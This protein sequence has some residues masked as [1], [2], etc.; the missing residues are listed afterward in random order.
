MGLVPSFIRAYFKKR[1]MLRFYAPFVKEGDLCFDIGAN[2]G[3]RTAV[4]LALGARVIAVEPQ[5]ACVEKLRERF[6]NNSQVTIV[7]AAVGHYKG[8]V[9][10]N[11]CNETSE[12]AT[13]SE[14]FMKAYGAVSNLH[15][16]NKEEVTMT[17]MDD[18]IATYGAPGFVKIDVEG[19]ESKVLEGLH[20]T[21]PCISFEFN[22]Q[23][24]AD[25]YK[26]L[27]IIN[28]LDRY[29]CNLIEYENFRWLSYDWLPIE[30]LAENFEFYMPPERLTGEIFAKKFS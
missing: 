23:L 20:H 17:T 25:T 19:Y 14:D 2:I 8:V 11:L 30:Y 28:E 26:T 3:E 5:K 27:R 4:F 21:I 6:A 24:L 18:L 10:L 29:E 16:P 22:Q 15:W 9:K 12:C 7:Q 13:F 1:A